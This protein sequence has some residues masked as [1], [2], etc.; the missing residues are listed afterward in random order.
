MIDSGR[1]PNR[2][3]ES[4]GHV[5]DG[6]TWPQMIKL[7]ITPFLGSNVLSITALHSGTNHTLRVEWSQ[8]QW[9]HMNSKGQGRGPKSLIRNSMITVPD[10]LEGKIQWTTSTPLANHS[11]RLIRIPVTGRKFRLFRILD[12]VIL[13][14]FGTNAVF[15][16]FG[17]Y[18]FLGIMVSQCRLRSL[19]WLGARSPRIRGSSSVSSVGLSSSG[20]RP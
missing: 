17:R 7:N 1:Q 8:Y 10:G 5:T 13:T 19:Y 16:D 9:R 20:I 6:V 14:S 3:T 2:G 18:W 12:S 15:S 11:S 4:N